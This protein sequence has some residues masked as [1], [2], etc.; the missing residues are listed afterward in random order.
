MN[1]DARILLARAQAMARPLPDARGAAARKQE[2]IEVLEFRLADERYAVQMGYVHA[3]HPLK[4]LTELPC[5][6]PFVLG[7]VSLRGHL[8]TVV[9]LKRFFGL[10]E[11]GLTDLHRIILVGDGQVE[12]GLL[13]D[14][15]VGVRTL[16]R[17]ALQ[18]G[19][20]TL[21]GIG[22]QYIQ[23]ITAESLIVLNMARILGDPR[24]LVDEELP[25]AA[26]IHRREEGL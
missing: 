11:Q 8:V 17:S 4:N 10:P 22:E 21:T 16:V 18:P 20:A 13:A 25:G 19:L 5:T 6:P 2:S 15:S 9:N 24:L 23:G 26:S 14:V 12:F 1:A 3:V 7:I